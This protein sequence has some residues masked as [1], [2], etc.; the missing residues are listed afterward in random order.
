MDRLGLR[1]PRRAN[2]VGPPKGLGRRRTNGVGP[3]KARRPLW[4]NGVGPPTH[5]AGVDITNCVH[6]RQAGSKI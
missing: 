6:A 3:P 2:A 1:L 5:K 4:S